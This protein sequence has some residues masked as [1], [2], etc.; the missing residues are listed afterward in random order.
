MVQPEK[1]L[2]KD[3]LVSFLD[4]GYNEAAIQ[5]QVRRGGAG[6]STREGVFGRP[7]KFGAAAPPFFIR[8]GPDHHLPEQGWEKI[9][10]H[11]DQWGPQ[12]RRRPSPGLPISCS[13]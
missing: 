4:G 7:L 12:W 11:I 6:G 1:T 5:T 2:S 9:G 3:S 10:E 8:R 13:R